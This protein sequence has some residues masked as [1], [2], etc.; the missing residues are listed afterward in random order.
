MQARKEGGCGVV[1]EK[2]ATVWESISPLLCD[3]PKYLQS[4]FM[5]IQSQVLAARPAMGSGPSQLARMVSPRARGV[6]GSSQGVGS[7][8]GVSHGGPAREVYH[9]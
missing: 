9:H 7:Q 4:G 3:F 8:T 5:A 6:G 1:T 2:A